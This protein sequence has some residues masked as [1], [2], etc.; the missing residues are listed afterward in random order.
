MD[1]LEDFIRKSH[2]AYCHSWHGF[3]C[4]CDI[5]EEVAEYKQLRDA[6]ASRLAILKELCEAY[7]HLRTHLNWRGGVR[8]I[9]KDADLEPLRAAIAKAERE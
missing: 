4:T 5:A 9:V 6:A 3:G 8:Y 7:K 1:K 2:K